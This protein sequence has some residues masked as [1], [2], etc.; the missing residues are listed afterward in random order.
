MS[1]AIWSMCSVARGRTSGVVMR[2]DRGVGEEA[3]QV[4][5]GQLR[6][7][8][9]GGRCA[10]DD[11]VVDVGDVHDPA[12]GVAAPAQVT[13]QQVREEERAEVADVGRAV[14]RRTARVDAD[15]VALGL[16]RSRLPG[17]RVVAAGGHR[18]VSSVAIATAEI[19]R[20]APSSPARLPLDA[21]TLTALASTPSS[22][23]D[24]R[25]HR[26]EVRGQPRPGG[27]DRQVDAGDGPARVGHA[28]HGPRPRAPRSRCRPGST[29][30]PGTAARG[31][32]GRLPRAGRRRR[33]GGRRRRPSG[34]GDAARPR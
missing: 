2:S 18:A 23:G 7:A 34:R 6:D 29:G 4:S 31:R 16:E 9:P 15:D 33:R 21:L 19:D 32:R 30:P 12:H 25:A 20:P 10:A 5:V 1:T 22:A 13:D 14:D 17:Q 8:D 27:H 3:R 28:P 11:L 24:R 26:L